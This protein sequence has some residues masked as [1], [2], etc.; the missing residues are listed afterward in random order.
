[1][2]SATRIDTDR[3][4]K[5]VEAAA[6]AAAV[7]SEVTPVAEGVRCKAKDAAEDA[8]YWIVRDGPT[9]MVRMATPDR[10]LSE[11]IEADLMHHGDPMEDLIEE[12]LVELGHDP[13][14]DGPMPT[15]KHFRSEDRLYTFE[16]PLPVDGAFAAGDLAAAT[17]IARRFLLAYE[18]AFRQLGDM[19]GGDED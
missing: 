11:S 10:W 9:W 14:T 15:V 19:A 12:E 4:L 17:A 13:R 16:N 3:F 8:W 6:T 7:F 2:T 5:D 1:M 18:A